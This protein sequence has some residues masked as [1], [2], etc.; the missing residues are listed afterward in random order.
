MKK[1]LYVRLIV[2]TTSFFINA[3][4]FAQS[5]EKEVAVLG[6]TASSITFNANTDALALA[7]I[8]AANSKMYNHFTKNFK[9]ATDL[10][11]HEFDGHV[12]INFK[13]HGVSTSTQYNEKGKWQFTISSYDESKLDEATR[14]SVESSYPG[15]LVAGTVIEVKVGDKSATLVMIE[16]KREWKR[17]RINDD[18]MSIYEQYIKQ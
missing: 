4:V 16:N 11:V 2:M 1:L 6:K 17:I 3:A 18:G 10:K 12:R 9:N 15:F 14:E 13:L 5:P 8:K 7:S